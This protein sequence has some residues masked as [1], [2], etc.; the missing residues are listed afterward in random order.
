[1]LNYLLEDIFSQILHLSQLGAFILQLQHNRLHYKFLFPNI[2]KEGR[3]YYE[4][5]K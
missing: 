3:P 4:E 1:M 5:G 2:R